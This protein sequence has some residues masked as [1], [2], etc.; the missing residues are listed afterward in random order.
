MIQITKAS[1]QGEFL[2]LEVNQIIQDIID[3]RY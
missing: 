3:A 2:V 1:E